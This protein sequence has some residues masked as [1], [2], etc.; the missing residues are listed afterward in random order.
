MAI[1]G[2]GP[3]KAFRQAIERRMTVTIRDIS[4]RRG[5]GFAPLLVSGLLL[6]G[7]MGSPTYGT[8]TPSD[9]QLLEDL[10]GVLSLAPDENERIEYKPRPAL[11]T[12]ASNDVLPPP[13]ENV[14]SAGNPNWPEAPERRRERL[15]AEAT[16][17]RDS[18][19]FEPSIE[20]D[21]SASR[22]R[23][24]P[25]NHRW[26][27]VAANSTASQRQEFNRRVAE[28][29]QGSP[30]A[31]RYLSEPPLEYRL[32]AATA[33]TDDIGEDEWTKEKRLKREARQNAGKTTWRDN[34]PWL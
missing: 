2:Q 30:T 10:T 27:D 25:R 29:K 31:R 19:D 3:G 32:P 22:E 18:P 7:C 28:S 8:G 13:Q 33:A 11:V 5:V 14:A 20:N 23:S 1:G 9:V 4:R 24:Q 17:G 34:I 15:R 6:S 12:P 16:A 26:E 21:I